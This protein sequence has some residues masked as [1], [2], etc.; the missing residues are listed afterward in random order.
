M[1]QSAPPAMSK[2]ATSTLRLY[3]PSIPRRQDWD[4]KARDF[5]TFIVDKEIK[6]NKQNQQNNTPTTTKEIQEIVFTPKRN[7]EECPPH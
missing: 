4:F 2:A 1:L 6:T 3:G 5:K 7:L